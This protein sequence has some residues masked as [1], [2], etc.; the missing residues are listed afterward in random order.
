V[1][2]RVGVTVD[3][4]DGNVGLVRQEWLLAGTTDCQDHGTR[5]HAGNVTR[6]IGR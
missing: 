3:G 4:G 5:T 2:G 6:T 1:V